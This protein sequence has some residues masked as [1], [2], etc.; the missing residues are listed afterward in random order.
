MIPFRYHLISLAAIFVALG[1][2]ILLGG[3]AGHSWITQGT[4]G[5]LSNMEAKYDRA[6]KSNHELRQQINRLMKEVARSNQEVV[7]L[8]SI[9][10]VNEL[11]GGKVYVWQEDGNVAEQ[12]TQLMHSV[13]MEVI[14]Y[15]EGN[16]WGDGV[17]LVVARQVPLWLREKQV[18][19][20][21]QVVDVPDS[22]AKQWA[23]LEQVQ[24]RLAE[25]KGSREKS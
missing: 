10:Y 13:G 1:V 8:M 25:R 20:W 4:K 14:S 23:L 17:L 16:N 3:T 18:N 24:N 12:I 5:I 6:L 19:S 11:A 2:G 9:R 15:H 22:P 7:Q 21:I